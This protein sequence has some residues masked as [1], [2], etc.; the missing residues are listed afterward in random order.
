MDVPEGS[1]YGI[2]FITN[3]VLFLHWGYSTHFIVVYM[4]I[5]GF[6]T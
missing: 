1:L 3:I 4:V 2:L 6:Y 5:I